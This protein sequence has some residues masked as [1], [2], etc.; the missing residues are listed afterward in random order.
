LPISSTIFFLS[1][2]KYPIEPDE[3]LSQKTLL[4]LQIMEK[5][6][7]EQFKILMHWN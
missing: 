1:E 5:I 7:E 6:I 4:Q 2:R 3:K